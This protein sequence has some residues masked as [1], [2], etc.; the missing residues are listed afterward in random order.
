MNKIFRCPYCGEKAFTFI[1]KIGFT[2]F[3]HRNLSIRCPSCDELC[4]KECIVFESW[5]HYFIRQM[6]RLICF[7]SIALPIVIKLHF[8]A[9]L[10]FPACLIMIFAFHYYFV[11]Y[12][13]FSI[14]KP[15]NKNEAKIHLEIDSALVKWPFIREGEIYDLI[16]TKNKL[17]IVQLF[18]I[19]K[20]KTHTVLY[21]RLIKP[22]EFIKDEIKE[23]YYNDKVIKV[24]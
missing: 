2:T 7:V 15:R 16:S 20:K 3:N 22:D 8:L 12:A 14:E 4:Y 17:Y 13:C 9:A 19:N 10:L 11:F 18:L 24:K 6:V 23:I 5:H 21:F 1:Q